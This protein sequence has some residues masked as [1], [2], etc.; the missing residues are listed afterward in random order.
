MTP[1]RLKQEHHLYRDAQNA[2]W[3]AR[4]RRARRVLAVRRAV[5]TGLLILIVVGVL[6]AA[7]VILSGH[8]SSVVRRVEGL[9]HHF[10]AAGTASSSMVT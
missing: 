6:G 1:V 7:A 8:G 3:E 9:D 5:R 2:Y 10:S 4:S